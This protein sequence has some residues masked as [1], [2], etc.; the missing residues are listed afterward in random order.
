MQREEETQKINSNSPLLCKSDSGF[1]FN[2]SEGKPSEWVQ[3]TTLSSK[4]ALSQSSGVRG[5]KALVSLKFGEVW[6]ETPFL[7]HL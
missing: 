7:V 6:I 1:V 5:A 3:T 2:G 4:S